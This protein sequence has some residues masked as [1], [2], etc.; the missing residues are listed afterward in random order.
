LGY[1]VL[2][3]GGGSSTACSVVCALVGSVR[4][5][6]DVAAEG[7]AAVAM[8]VGGMD[9]GS[10]AMMTAPFLLISTYRHP[11]FSHENVLISGHLCLDFAH[12]VSLA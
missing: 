5:L 10:S 12:V 3:G 11:E 2:C 1:V 7:L 9:T 4:E 8:T 6:A